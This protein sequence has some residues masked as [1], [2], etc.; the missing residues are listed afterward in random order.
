M[1]QSGF[2]PIQ[3]YRSSTAAAVPTAGNLVAGEL[4]INTTDEKLY[5]ENASGVVKLLASSAFVGTVTSVGLSGGTTG[6]TVSGTNP[7]T[8]SGTF[9]LGGT[10]AVANGGT[11]VTTSTGTVAVVLS[12]TPTLVT[13]ILGAATATSIANGLGAV[14]T[15]SYT[16]TGDLNTGMWSPAADTIAVSTAGAERVRVTSAGNVGIGTSS[17]SYALDVSA[18]GNISGQFKTSGSINALYLADAGTTA[19]TLYVGT[20]GND[21]RVVTGSNERMRILSTGLVGI[22]N[23]APTTALDVSGSITAR[24]ASVITDTLTNYGANLVINAA[25]SLDTIFQTNGTERMRLTTGGNVGIGTS[26][27]TEK[28]DV[29]GNAKISSG[30]S[31]YWGDATSQITAVNA[32]AMRFLTGTASEKM[33]I[34]ASGRVGI[35]TTAPNATLVV[36]GTG[37]IGDIAGA[38]NA[39]YLK[40]TAS[41]SNQSNFI[42]FGSAGTASSC[43]IG[44]D[45]NANGTTVGQLNIEAGGSGGVFLASGGT[46]WTAVSDE[47]AKD[48]IE[49]IS[50]AVHKVGTLRAVIGKYKTDAEGTR[51]SFLI[52]QDVQAVLPEAVSVGTDEQQTLG[53]A[54][55]DTIPLL[56]AAIKEL[57]ARVAQLEGK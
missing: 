10:L 46:S 12:N 56:V 35:G 15:P 9:T 7:I 54:Y 27:P 25:G 14:G 20:V 51:R 32:G 21:F 55:T 34:D 33:R 30:S 42:V 45:I 6:L 8:S 18:T 4:A 49:P 17:P 3:L 22:G 31:F 50:N 28:L 40:H 19:G 2:T 36:A 53:V 37:F 24:S 11:G 26:A 5:F 1:S 43:F 13:P 41:T 39:L 16:F 48:I 47:R 38:R 23:T 57:T 29:A 52:A 44:N